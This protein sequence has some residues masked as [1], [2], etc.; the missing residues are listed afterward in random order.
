M[1]KTFSMCFLLR[2]I[3]DFVIVLAATNT[4][5]AQS[6]KVVVLDHADSLIGLVIDGEQARQLVGN[7]RFHQDNIIV[8]CRRAVQYRESN[9]I[10]FEGEAEVWDGKMR[11]VGSRGVYYGDT[12]IAEAFERVMLEESTTTLKAAYGKY[13]AEEKRA[14]FSTDVSVE[15]PISLMLCNELTYFRE[16]QKSIAVGSVKI[17]NNR[18]GLNIYGNHFENFK[19]QKFSRMTEQPMVV[20]IDTLS[21][22][23]RDTLIVRSKIMEAYQDTLERL[24]ATDSVT[25]TRGELAAEAGVCSFFTVLDSMILH[26]S[27]VIWYSTGEHGDNQVSGDS[28]FIK[29]Q[30]RKLE[31]VYVRGDA[32]T[33]S[34]ADSIYRNRFHQMTGQEIIL[35][36]SGD[37]IYSI[38]VDR[39]ATS[40]YYLFDKARGN[41]VNKSTGDHVTILFSEGKVD[42]LKVI[43]GTEGQYF[44]E[45]MILKRENDYNLPG[46]NWKERKK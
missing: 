31:T 30:K 1:T 36:F 33:I 11:M 44:P 32:F 20:Q 15:D 9:K 29:L 25:I 28:I 21:D 39:T 7:V 14:Y 35:R 22:G 38:D 8:T 13:F 16:E 46:F 37:Q 12:K 41:G 4:M 43:G 42:A 5:L 6:E 27:P 2:C 45:K 40:L 10:T 34:R 23:K 26:K 3:L 24:I 17:T 18:N 19:K